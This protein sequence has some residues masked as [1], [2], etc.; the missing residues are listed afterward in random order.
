MP[1][2]PAATPRASVSPRILAARIWTSVLPSSWTGSG[3]VTGEF[4]PPDAVVL[5]PFSWIMAV[6]WYFGVCT[7]E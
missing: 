4:W 5:M 3:R 1:V 6:D 2:T 7:F